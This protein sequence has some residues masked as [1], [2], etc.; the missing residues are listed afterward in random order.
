MGA[1]P[2]CD[3]LINDKVIVWD[4]GLQCWYYMYIGW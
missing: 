2:K 3:I 4:L 1:I